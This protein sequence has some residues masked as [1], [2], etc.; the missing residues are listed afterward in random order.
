VLGDEGGVLHGRVT[1][2]RAI[3]RRKP[4]SRSVE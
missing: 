1:S 4:G 2:P 3:Q